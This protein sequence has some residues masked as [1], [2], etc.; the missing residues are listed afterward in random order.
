M[1]VSFQTASALLLYKHL[2]ASVFTPSTDLQRRRSAGPAVVLR[3]GQR[4][5]PHIVA[6]ICQSRREGGYP[7]RGTSRSELSRDVL[8]THAQRSTKEARGY[9]DELRAKN[10]ARSHARAAR[11]G[12]RAVFRGRHGGQENPRS[13]RRV[14]AGEM[15]CTLRTPNSAVEK[16]PD[17]PQTAQRTRVRRHNPTAS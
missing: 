17:R 6:H 8:A 13:R 1:F 12:A 11:G 3:R 7:L 4:T 16:Q 15:V 10:C 9:V 5:G 14:S 2:T